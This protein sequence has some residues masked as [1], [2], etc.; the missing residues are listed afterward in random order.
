MTVRGPRVI[1]LARRDS[2][3]SSF[4]RREEFFSLG[5]LRV[6]HDH[7][8]RQTIEARVVGKH[9]G[10]VRC[11]V[12]HFL[13]RPLSGNDND[14]RN[15]TEFAAHGLGDD[16]V[17]GCLSS[18]PFVAHAKDNRFNGLVRTGDVDVINIVV[19]RQIRSDRRPAAHDTQ[20]AGGN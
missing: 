18:R 3:Q 4:E 17:V 11:L 16:R 7:A 15:V 14:R 12:G 1:G 6:G 2:C 5:P 20:E 9:G 8:R 19:C 10:H 13:A